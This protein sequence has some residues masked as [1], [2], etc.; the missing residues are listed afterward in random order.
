M[1]FVFLLVMFV[2]HTII[3][4]D[5]DRDSSPDNRVF[6]VP[7]RSNSRP[8]IERVLMRSS[9]ESGV[10]S[11]PGPEGSIPAYISSLVA[12]PDRS[13][14][15]SSSFHLDSDHEKCAISDHDL[16]Q[17]GALTALVANKMY[18]SS[19]FQK[20][21]Y[22]ALDLS[23]FNFNP[24]QKR[25]LGDMLNG[26]LERQ[27]IMRIDVNAFQR[28]RDENKQRTGEIERM[29]KELEML[30]EQLDHQDKHLAELCGVVHDFQKEMRTFVN[31][32]A[33]QHPSKEKME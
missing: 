18:G 3:P 26:L 12:S 23:S 19:D 2:V 6:R 22:S 5:T 33:I 9:D 20:N 10:H 7:S 24:E 21:V 8:N 28:I 15:S 25:T 32:M 13:P 30:Q 29:T 1:K 27:M 4:S 11:D 14:S 31:L 16:V 17:I